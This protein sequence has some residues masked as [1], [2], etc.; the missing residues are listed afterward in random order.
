MDVSVPVNLE[1]RSSGRRQT[2]DE[3]LELGPGDVTP[4]GD[5]DSAVDYL[6]DRGLSR[7]DIIKYEISVCTNK[8]HRLYPRIIF[9]VWEYWTGDLLGHIG[10]TYTNQ[11]PRYMSALPYIDMVG[12]R[13]GAWKDVHVLVEGVFDGIRAHQAGFQSAILLGK[14]ANLLEEWA[15]LTDRTDGIVIVLDG[16]AHDQAKEYY[17]RIK[18]IRTNVWAYLMPSDMDPADF[19]PDVLRTVVVRTMENKVDNSIG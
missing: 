12:Y 19:D 8:E 4:A 17:H 15:A 1:A 9:P 11:Q 5:I 13:E 16:D 2:V 6:A 7:S 14:S 18:P 3:G 10:R